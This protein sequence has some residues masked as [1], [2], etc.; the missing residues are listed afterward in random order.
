MDNLSISCFRDCL[1][2]Y[3]VGKVY[4]ADLALRAAEVIVPNQVVQRSNININFDSVSNPTTWHIEFDVANASRSE[5]GWK[6]GTNASFGPAN[7][8][9][10]YNTVLVNIGANHVQDYH[11]AGYS[12][13]GSRNGSVS[14]GHPSG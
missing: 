9:G 10:T 14:G 2:C 13:Q 6:D 8:D 1:D 5:L 11:Q 3:R 12:R 4:S 7:A